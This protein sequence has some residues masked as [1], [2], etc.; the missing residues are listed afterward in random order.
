[1]GST[2]WPEVTDS[3]QLPMPLPSRIKPSREASRE[4]SRDSRDLPPLDSRD[5]PPLDSGEVSKDSKV[6]LL[7]ASKASSR[8]SRVLHLLPLLSRLASSVSRA[9]LPSRAL[10]QPLTR[11]SLLLEALSTSKASLIV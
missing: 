1:M 10:L 7:L 9:Q 8:A 11:A 6:L 4:A 5:Q 2:T 3:P